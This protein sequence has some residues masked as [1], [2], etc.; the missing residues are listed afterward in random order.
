MSLADIRTA[1]LIE[2][3]AVQPQAAQVLEVINKSAALNQLRE[4][5]AKDAKIA[6]WRASPEY[7]KLQ[8][9]SK[10]FFADPMKFIG[11]PATEEKEA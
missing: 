10:A 2:H 5:V 8:E 4:T 7:A 3:I 6:K 9:S 1:N 11:P